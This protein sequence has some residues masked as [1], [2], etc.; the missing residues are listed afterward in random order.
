MGQKYCNK[1][2]HIWLAASNLESK[3]PF[4]LYYSAQKCTRQDKQLV[5]QHQNSLKLRKLS[6]R[7]EHR[8]WAHFQSLSVSGCKCLDM[9]WIF[10]WFAISE[11]SRRDAS[12]SAKVKDG[13]LRILWE[14]LYCM[15][16]LFDSISFTIPGDFYIWCWFESK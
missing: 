15:I 8:M 3:C 13:N 14:Q 5:L 6:K 11:R 16:P 9:E 2:H 12:I 4:G 1:M 10:D 7:E